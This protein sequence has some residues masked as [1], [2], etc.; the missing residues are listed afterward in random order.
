MLCIL[1]IIK[2]NH[3]LHTISIARQSRR[4]RAQKAGCI[5]TLYDNAI[6]LRKI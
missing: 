1:L 5:V 2:L 6:L 4:E 3:K